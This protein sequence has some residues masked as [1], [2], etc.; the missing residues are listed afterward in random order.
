MSGPQPGGS[1]PGGNKTGEAAAKAKAW[2]GKAWTA[3]RA[4][5]TNKTRLEIFVE[6]ALND[7]PWG[8]TGAQM[9][10]ALV[11]WDS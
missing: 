9:N 11:R 2:L 5:A 6:D 8:P 3:S 1:A 10:G 4:L 7:V